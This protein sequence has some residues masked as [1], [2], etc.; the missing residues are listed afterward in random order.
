[1]SFDYHK[2][3]DAPFSELSG[4]TINR[5]MHVEDIDCGG[6]EALFFD[7]SGGVFMMHHEQDCCESVSIEDSGGDP[8]DLL[9]HVVLIAEE[10][11]KSK[12]DPKW[13]DSETWTFYRLATNVGDLCI[14]WHGSSNGFYSESVS[15]SRVDS[16]PPSAVEWEEVT[17]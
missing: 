6:N 10:S 16:V 11:C 15:F 8:D 17:S 9:G 2:R 4:L 14:R 1:M 5:I 13:D 3:M 12:Q 7:T